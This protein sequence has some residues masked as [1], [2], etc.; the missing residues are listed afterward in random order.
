MDQFKVEEV[1]DYADVMQIGARN[2]QNFA[3]LRDVGRYAAEHEKGVLLKT[4]SLPKLM[5]VLCAVEYIALEGAEKIIICERGINNSDNC[6]RNTPRP[7][8][9]ME[10]RKATYLPVIGD[11]SHSTGKRDLVPQIAVEYLNAAANG[12][13]IDVIRDDENSRINGIKVCDYE[14][15]LRTSDFKRFM[16]EIK[17][18]KV[19]QKWF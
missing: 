14:Q 19:P 7:N 11:P 16:E 10:L 13:L 8:F 6:M 12:L 15:G 2:M 5:E 9:L 4:G 1:G 3:L 18:R 17:N